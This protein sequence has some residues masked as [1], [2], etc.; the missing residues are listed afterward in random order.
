MPVDQTLTMEREGVVL[1]RLR[2]QATVLH[3][4]PGQTFEISLVWLF[5]EYLF[6]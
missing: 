1:V 4:T 6:H 3:K 2:W 5:E